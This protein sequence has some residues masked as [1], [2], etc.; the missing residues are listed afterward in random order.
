MS[1]SSLPHT[2]I[3]RQ[4]LEKYAAVYARVSTAEQADKGYSLPTQIEACLAFAE[5]EGYVISP[6]ISLWREALCCLREWEERR[7]DEQHD[8]DKLR[9]IGLWNTIVQRLGEQHGALTATNHVFVEDYTGM[10]LNRPQLTKLRDL[11]HQRLVQAIFVYDLDR[12]SRKLAHQLLL[13]EEFEQAGVALRII[14]MPEGAKTPEV[15]L[16]TNVR[17]V[18]AEYERSK[19]LERTER[20]RRGRAQA[21]RPPGG[22]PP[23]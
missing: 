12:L 7:K 5:R 20:G 10:S 19:I 2:A 14:T 3:P 9:G 16:L 21:G 4:S 15:Q 22:R 6:G 1:T 23:L 13:C 17:G 8:T 18:I 11:V